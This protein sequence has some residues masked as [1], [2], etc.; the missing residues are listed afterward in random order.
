MI[1]GLSLLVNKFVQGSTFETQTRLKP[2]NVLVESTE[3]QLHNDCMCFIE[4]T[5]SQMMKF[6]HTVFL[7]KAPV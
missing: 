3:T 5:V 6:K 4:Q 2:I 7:C 1:I